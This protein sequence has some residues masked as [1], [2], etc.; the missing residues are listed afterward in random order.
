MFRIVV[1]AAL[2]VAVM[3]TIKDGR[4]LEETGL[5]SSCKPVATPLGYNGYWEACRAGK[6]E[7]RP[8]LSRRSCVS[9]GIAQQVEYWSCPSRIASGQTG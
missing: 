2:I 9:Q 6:L 4:T 3:A 7:G 8:N 1:V 5:L